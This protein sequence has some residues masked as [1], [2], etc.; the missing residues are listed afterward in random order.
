MVVAL[1]AS[2]S[3]KRPVL[4]GTTPVAPVG[5]FR[6]AVRGNNGSVDTTEQQTGSPDQRLGAVAA[7]FEEGWLA[8]VLL[9]LLAILVALERRS[10][11]LRTRAA[12]D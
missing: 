12:V 4:I 6:A 5:W 10:R 3:G 1:P 11:R 2:R 9:G 7:R 8:G